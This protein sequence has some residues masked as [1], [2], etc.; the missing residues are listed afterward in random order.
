MVV[1]VLLSWRGWLTGWLLV[2]GVPLG[3]LLGL[4]LAVV[5]AP[6]RRKLA[7]RSV[8][9]QASPYM[10]DKRPHIIAHSF[11][12]YLTATMLQEVP[13]ARARRVVLVGCVLH[14]RRDWA[15]LKLRKRDAFDEVRNDWTNKD[16]VVWLAGWIERRIPGFGQAGRTGFRGRPPI[17]H[18]VD[19]PT[20]LCKACEAV[21]GALVHNVDCSGLGH[22]DAFIGPAHAARFWLPFLWGI[23]P[24]EYGFLLD[25]CESAADQQELGNINRLKVVE[26]ELL[27]W[28]W[29]WADRQTLKD[30]ITGLAQEDRRRAGRSVDELVGRIVRVFWQAIE[31]GRTARETGDP[32]EARWII[33]LFP[34]QAVGY[35]VDQV[36]ASP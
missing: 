29:R 6:V 28:E 34:W 23:D 7:L 5:A 33:Y 24:A 36:L 16:A 30:Y 11:G 22:S 13:A 14:D 25:F 12:T 19:H 3:L 20:A 4:V 32:S 10:K 18:N 31:R 8:W 1:A 27:S 26:D 21:P 35:A 17:V 9:R 2:V 15:A